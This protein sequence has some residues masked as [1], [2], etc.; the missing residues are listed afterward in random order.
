MPALYFLSDLSRGVTGEIHHVD[1]GY[2]VVGM[3]RPDAPDI[4]SRDGRQGRCRGRLI[5]YIRHGETDW[6]A[7]GR[8]Q[9]RRDIA[10]Q[11]A[12]PRAGGALRRIL[13]DLFARDGRDRCRVRYVSSPLGARQRD[14]GTERAA[15]WT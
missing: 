10:A 5:Y 12:R 6:N 3:K 15:R 8:L 11:R 14:H 2:H 9:G 1:S 4:T 13:R 7:E